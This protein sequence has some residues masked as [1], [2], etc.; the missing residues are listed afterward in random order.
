MRRLK[1]SLPV[2]A[3]LLCLSVVPIAE[4]NAG[5]PGP[6]SV[7]ASVY[8][9]HEVFAGAFW[10]EDGPATVH[11]T[12]VSFIDSSSARLRASGPPPEHGSELEGG[13]VVNFYTSECDKTTSLCTYRFGST[14]VSSDEFSYDP[15][16][17]S[18][19]IDTEI[20]GCRI[21]FTFTASGLPTA[22]TWDYRAV[23]PSNGQ[24]VVSAWSNASA[25]RP[26]DPDGTLCD[27]R[28][29]GTPFS[30]MARGLQGSIDVWAYPGS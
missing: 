1:G 13:P 15:L 14:T 20:D 9:R 29:Q 5:D 22:G 8:L 6:P 21:D 27:I 19:S 12:S 16:L 25:W 26:A 11:W 30:G 24:V 7:G 23:D 17:D 2:V 10:Y 4:G 3:C 28:P 18:V